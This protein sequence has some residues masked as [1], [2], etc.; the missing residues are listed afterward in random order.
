VTAPRPA[1]AAV[2]LVPRLD[3]DGL[4]D[5]LADAIAYRTPDGGHC[6]DCTSQQ[7]PC[8][9]HQ[10]DAARRKAYQAL[11]ARCRPPGHTADREASQ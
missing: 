1:P 11:L 5:A 6:H 7:E 4:R 9:D 10:D 8:G 2:P 3:L